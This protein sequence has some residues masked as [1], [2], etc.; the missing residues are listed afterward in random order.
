MSKTNKKI[1]TTTYL[2]EATIRQLKIYAAKTNRSMS[3]VV[4]SSVKEYI[5]EKPKKPVKEQ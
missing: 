1:T 5:K 2:P 3:D 4:N